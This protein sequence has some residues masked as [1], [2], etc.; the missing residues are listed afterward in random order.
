MEVEVEVVLCLKREDCLIDREMLRQL[1]RKKEKRF[2][3]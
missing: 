2:K 3:V 1:R